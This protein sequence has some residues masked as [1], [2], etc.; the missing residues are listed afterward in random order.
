MKDERPEPK[1]LLLEDLLAD[2]PAG[3]NSAKQ[4]AMAAFRRARLF[5]NVTRVS[6]VAALIAVLV[7]GAF[8][9]RA[10]PVKDRPSSQEL[11]GMPDRTVEQE[12]TSGTADSRA[13]PTLSDEELLASFP[14]HS[15][16]LAE[17]DGRKILIFADSS[18]QKKYLR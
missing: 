8:L 12:P 13:L 10:Q 14:P 4:H 11:R 18:L 3:R 5:K 9:F 15:C 16:Y 6:R 2:D 7:V 17:V 1:Q